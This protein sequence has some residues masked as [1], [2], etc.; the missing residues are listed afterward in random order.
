MNDRFPYGAARFLGALRRNN[1]KQWFDEHRSDYE[2]Q[3][4]E[5]A[6]EFVIDLGAKLRTLRPKLQ[7]DPRTNTMLPSDF[8]IFAPPRRIGATWTQ[9]PTNRFRRPWAASLCAISDSWCG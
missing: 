1:R 5:P 9:W 6:K 3:L 2:E 8:D 4:L 7:V